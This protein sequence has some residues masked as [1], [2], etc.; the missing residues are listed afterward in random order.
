METKGNDKG[1]SVRRSTAADVDVLLALADEARATMRASGNMNQWV[2]G[3]PSREVFERDIA[4]GVS[5]VVVD[6]DGLAVGAFAFVPSP[7]PTYAAI[8]EG[9]WLDDTAPYHVIH[10]IASRA[11]SHGVLA[12]IIDW[13][14]RQDANLRIDTHRDNV[15]MRRL[16]PR[17]GFTYCGIIYLA[18][19]AERLAYQLK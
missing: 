16:L 13:C 11:G 1:Y 10:R 2:N 8:Y 6:G 18:D 7:E 9:C 5:F 12:V 17:L 4:L 14:R 15:I 19:G 3:Y